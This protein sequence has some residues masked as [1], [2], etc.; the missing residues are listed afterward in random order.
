M[1]PHERENMPDRGTG[2]C[3]GT[4]ESFRALPHSW[5]RELRLLVRCIAVGVAA[6]NA[7]AEVV[8]LAAALRAEEWERFGDLAIDRHRVAPVVLR[9]AAAL[10]PPAKTLAR[11]QVAAMDAALSGLRQKAETLRM[12]DALG[13]AGIEPLL[14]KGWALAER[15]HGSAAL[16]QSRDIDLLVGD[17]EFETAAGIVAGLGYRPAQSP[18]AGAARRR[19][20]ERAVKDIEFTIPGNDFTLELHARSIAYRGWPGL[21][22]LKAGTCVHAIDDTGR[23]IAVP[24]ARGDLVFLSV[25]GMQHVFSRLRWLHDI[26]TLVEMRSDA[27]LAGDLAAARRIAA[28]R[29]VRIAVALAGTVFGSRWPEP[30]PRPTFSERMAARLI[31]AAVAREDF[32]GPQR[33]AAMRRVAL[34]FVVAGTLRQRLSLLDRSRRVLMA[35]HKPG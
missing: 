30:W 16:R 18:A 2:P 7:R 10:A 26:A 11:L 12:L 29:F 24:S 4:T 1:A 32:A 9:Q 22:A 19:P 14:L 21:A 23:R 25:H 35:G 5:P 13:A 6:E 8:G 27:D 15:L 34:K 33:R 3:R 17:A 28:G 20:S 31:L